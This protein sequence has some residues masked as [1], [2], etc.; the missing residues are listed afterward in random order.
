M[1]SDT[2]WTNARYGGSVTNATNYAG[3]T[4]GITGNSFQGIFYPSQVTDA[5]ILA[6]SATDSVYTT[7]LHTGNQSLPTYSVREV[8]SSEL[9][10]SLLTGS[11]SFQLSLDDYS[12]N[13]YL[14]EVGDLIKIITGSIPSGPF[15]I[16]APE[17]V[18]KVVAIRASNI[19]F[20]TTITVEVKRGWSNTTPY[21]QTYAAG[22]GIY[23]ID[24]VKTY[25]LEGSKI[26]GVTRGKIRVQ[27]TGDILYVDPLGVV[28]TGSFS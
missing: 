5:E 21:N 6:A 7:Y 2:G 13:S 19:P 4:P 15:I 1:Q 27:Y 9:A 3:L 25:E 17:E 11:T 14:L 10:I 23:K 12:L 24:P 26:Q 18:M 28:Y 16:P 20:D 8:A 22:Q